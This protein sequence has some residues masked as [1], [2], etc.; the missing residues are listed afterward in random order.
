MT[1]GIEL[2]TLRLKTECSVNELS[3]SAGTAPPPPPFF[4]NVT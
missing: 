2:I 3:A 4:F 1:E